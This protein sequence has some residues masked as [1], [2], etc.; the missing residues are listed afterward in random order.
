MISFTYVAYFVFSSLM[1]KPLMVLQLP[2]WHNYRCSLSLSLRIND[3]VFFV[4]RAASVRTSWLIPTSISLSL[5]G[6]YQVSRQPILSTTFSPS[7][8]IGTLS[9]S[10]WLLLFL[11]DSG[12]HFAIDLAYFLTWI[13]S[14]FIL[15]CSFDWRQCCSLAVL[16]SWIHRMVKMN[17]IW[18]TGNF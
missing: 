13:F 18:S 5:I 3:I 8:L 15:I 17:C 4:T 11:G 16:C 9:W 14:C 7:S 2:Q 1:F 6:I 10:F 12:G